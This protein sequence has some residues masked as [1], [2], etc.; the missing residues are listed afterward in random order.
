MPKG[1]GPVDN[2]KLATSMIA[3]VP[4]SVILKEAFDLLGSLM[5]TKVNPPE[6]N[7]TLWNADTG[8]FFIK[9]SL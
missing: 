5:T 7:I 8:V 9:D 6:F 1:D 3:A 2:K 4:G